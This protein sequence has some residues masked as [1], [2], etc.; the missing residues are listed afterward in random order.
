VLKV[1]EVL[2]VLKVLR[3]RCDLTRLLSAA[4]V[5]PCVLLRH[6]C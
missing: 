2:E 1:L 4:K 5:V 6:L 3:F